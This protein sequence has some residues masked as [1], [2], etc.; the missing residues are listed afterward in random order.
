[1]IL[2]NGADG[3]GT[4]FSCSVPCFNPVDIKANILRILDREP[5]IPMNPWYRGFTGR[6][7]KKDDQVWTA[8][9]TVTA[10]GAVTE[11]PP[12]LWTQDYKEHLESLI[13]SGK[14]RG[15]ENHSTETR[16][17]FVIQGGPVPVPQKDIRTSNMYLVTPNGIRKF[18]SPEEIL[19]E[20]TKVR[21]Q[22]YKAR[23]KHLKKVLEEKIQKLDQKR[24]FIDMVIRGTLVVFRRPKGELVAEMIGLGLP[25]SLLET[26]TLEYTEENV[27]AL[28]GILEKTRAELRDLE[29]TGLADMWKRD[30][31]VV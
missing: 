26:R 19:F 3:I 4:G 1:M 18:D 27:V 5:M 24:I 14:I 12:G 7:E 31:D 28:I 11:L 6:I 30:L 2:V 21:L 22:F 16:P 29:A 13:D 23:K 25:E 9:G 17:N 8:Y 20:Y 15:Y 10:E